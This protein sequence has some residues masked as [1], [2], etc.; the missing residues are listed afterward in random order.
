MFNSIPSLFEDGR[1]AVSHVCVFC[2][3]FFSQNMEHDERFSVFQS[4]YIVKQN[5]VKTGVVQW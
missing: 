1:I 3:E 4:Y 5:N 2:F